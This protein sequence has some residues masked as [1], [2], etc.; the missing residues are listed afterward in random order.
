LIEPMKERLQR[1]VNNI[2]VADIETTI[3]NI[4]GG[5]AAVPDACAAYPSGLGDGDG[6][7]LG[8]KSTGG[9]ITCGASADHENVKM[10]S[11]SS[12]LRGW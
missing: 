9:S 5:D 7:P 6:T 12:H 8:R 11:H 3:S 4:P 10:F 1:L 2:E